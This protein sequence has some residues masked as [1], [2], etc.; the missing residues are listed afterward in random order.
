MHYVIGD[1]HGCYDEL[2]DLLQI[3]EAQDKDARYIFVGDFIDR[4]KKVWDVLEWAMQHITLDGKYQSVRGNHEQMVLEWYEV[5]TEWKKRG[6]YAGT[7]EEMLETNYD[8]SRWLE[9]HKCMEVEKLEPIMKFFRSLPYART[10]TVTNGS[11]QVTYKIVHAWYD[12]HET[13]RKAQQFKNIWMR[14]YEGNLVTEDIIV[15]GHTPTFDLDFLRGDKSTPRPGL[16]NYR[17]NAINLDGDCVFAAGVSL[18]CMLCAICLETLEEFYHNTLEEGF[19]ELSQYMISREE[20]GKR[21]G[22]YRKEFLQDE[23]CYRKEMLERLGRR[24]SQCN[25]EFCGESEACI[26]E[27]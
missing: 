24:I 15:H 10:L 7:G 6:G 13:S 1:V 26:G 17:K 8:F 9:R 14:C 23:N 5:W 12:F 20:A 22:K 19:M 25:Q 16:I 11:S 18:P 3:I 27:G 4:G 2:M 21:A